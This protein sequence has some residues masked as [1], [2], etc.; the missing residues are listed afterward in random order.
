MTLPLTRPP[1]G[2]AGHDGR[3]R[4][5]PRPPWWPGPS[6]L[7]RDR[8]RHW[9]ERNPLSR[10]WATSPRG[11]AILLAVCTLFACAVAVFSTN[12]PER[13]WGIMAAG[14]YGI[15]ALAALLAGRRGRRIAVAVAL[16]GTVIVPLAWM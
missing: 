4:S 3:P 7:W 2:D 1:R 15:A 9:Q 10:A 11:G 16:A 13:L 14:P 8:A 6:R 12:P 5:A